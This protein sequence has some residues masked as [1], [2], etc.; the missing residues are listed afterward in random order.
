IGAFEFGA[1][2]TG[3]EGEVPPATNRLAVTSANPF[4][5]RA[6]VT[7]TAAERQHVAVTLY[8]A[9]GRRLGVVF[10]GELSA[11]IP[12]ALAVSGRDLPAGV[13]VLMVEGERFRDRLLLT[14]AH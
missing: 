5:E 14:R 13:Y 10:E 9:L 11:G 7:L 4:N 2:A 8:D 1:T 3:P 12:M 6:L